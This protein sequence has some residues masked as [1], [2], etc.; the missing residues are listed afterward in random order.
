MDE[1]SSNKTGHLT[2][3]EAETYLPPPERYLRKHTGTGGNHVRAKSARTHSKITFIK[4]N[5]LMIYYSSLY[6]FYRQIC[7]S[8]NTLLSDWLKMNFSNFFIAKKLSNIKSAPFNFI[9]SVKFL[10]LFFGGSPK[11]T[12]AKL[13]E[14][15]LK[16]FIIFMSSSSVCRRSTWSTKWRARQQQKS[17]SA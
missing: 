11:P 2:M 8:I 6:S 16:Y 10:P 17:P 5:K 1:F 12:E 15:P 3:G 14:S 13:K 7:Y 4:H 9:Q